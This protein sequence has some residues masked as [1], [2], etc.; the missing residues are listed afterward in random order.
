MRR[1][2]HGYSL[3]IVGLAV[4]V[5]AACGGGGGDAGTPMVTVN[6][7]KVSTY[8]TD[9]LATEYSQVW[10]GVLKLAVVNTD[11]GVETVLF[12]STTPAVYNLSSL[13]SVGQLMSAVT[14]PA[15]VYGKVLVTLDS[16]VQ[17]VSLDGKSTIN[18]NLRADGSP[19]TVPVKLDFDTAS[20]TPIVI[21]FNLAKFSYDAA[22]GLVTPTLEKKDPAQPFMREQAAVRGA[23]VSVSSDGFV[24]D[25]ARLGAGL[26]VKLATDGVILD[27]ATHRVLALTDLVVGKTIEAK[28]MVQRPANAGDSVTLTASV[29]RVV[30]LAHDQLPPALKFTGG[31]GTV[32][33]IN[34]ALIT[35]ALSEAGF[36]PGANGNSVVVDASH[37]V[38]THGAATDLIVGRAIGFRG[39]FDTAG[40][41]QALF[42][43]VEGAPSQNDRDTHPNLRF[44]DLAATVISLSGTTLSVTANPGEGTQ[45]STVTTYTV[46]ISKAELKSW[47][48]T[49]LTAGQHIRV[50]GALTGTSMVALVVEV[51]GSCLN[52]PMT[53]TPPAPPASAASNP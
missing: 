31:E 26:V 7:V 18:A 50:K 9:N 52:A 16:K 37:A 8:I 23:L 13:A 10:V 20:P 39:Q 47:G 34:G 30:D 12:E 53:P 45:G 51:V 38:Y 2:N 3:S 4:A 17:L 21:D 44:A 6:S 46:D 42:V 32:T 29:V 28:G 5:L 36:L 22:T 43:D 1:W 19:V 25:D 15:G 48:T 49:C 27:E 33:A 40:V 35:V 24:M 11:T 41:M 14:I